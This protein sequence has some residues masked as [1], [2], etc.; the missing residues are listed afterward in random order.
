MAIAGAATIEEAYEWLKA[1]VK[2]TV[3]TVGAE[4]AVA[5]GADEIQ[6]QTPPPCGEVVDATGAGDAFNVRRHSSSSATQHSTSN[7][8]CAILG[9]CSTQLLSQLSVCHMLLEDSLL[10]LFP[11]TQTSPHV[12]WDLRQAGFIHGWL[13]DGVAE[14]LLW[15]CCCGTAAI[16]KIGAS[17][18]TDLD[19]VVEMVQQLR[20]NK[21]RK[22]E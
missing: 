5:V 21:K 11:P 8:H 18:P 16:G 4:G 19:T 6:R 14:G 7:A 22:V 2:L 3:L 9:V 20:G 1:H 17:S 10:Y 13:K 12:G 15:G